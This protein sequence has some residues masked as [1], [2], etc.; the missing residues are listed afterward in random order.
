MTRVGERTD[1][2]AGDE[3]WHSLQD[4]FISSL[5]QLQY[6]PLAY[7]LNE[8]MRVYLLPLFPVFIRLCYCLCVLFS[9]FSFLLSDFYPLFPFLLVRI[10]YPWLQS[11]MS[12]RLILGFIQENDEL[13]IMKNE[14]LVCRSTSSPDVK[15]LRS[16]RLYMRLSTILVRQLL[17]Y[18]PYMRFCIHS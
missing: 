14:Y 1:S 12:H 9:S 6:F 18:N 3:D 5:S 15:T 16:Q 4:V 2:E 11:T 10:S 7:I 8:W 17:I 13:E